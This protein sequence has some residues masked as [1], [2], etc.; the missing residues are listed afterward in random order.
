LDGT[1]FD[2]SGIGL[3]TSR[4]VGLELLYEALNGLL[5]F[6]ILEFEAVSLF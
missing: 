2:Y 1:N 5:L 4:V 6:L 3:K